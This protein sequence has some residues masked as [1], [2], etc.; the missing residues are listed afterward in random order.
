M[1]VVEYGPEGIMEGMDLNGAK[2]NILNANHARR[3]NSVL[4]EFDKNVHFSL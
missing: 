4:L 2:S 3:Q 1:T